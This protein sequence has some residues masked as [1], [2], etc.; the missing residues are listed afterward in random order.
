MS[1]SGSV[2]SSF[3]LKRLRT[4][5]SVAAVTA[6]LT[7]CVSPEN[8]AQQ[9]YDNGLALIAKNDDLN[10]R[11]ELLNSIKYK[12]DNIDV[13]RALAG[14]DERTKATQRLFEDLRRIVE[15]DP[16]DLENRLKLA[17]M[18]VAGGANDAA[19]KLIEIANED[20]KPNAAIHALKALI[21]VRTKDT[22]GAVREAE[23]AL[24]IDPHNVDA[25]TLV[26]AKLASDGDAGA[27]LKLLDTAPIDPKNELRVSL[28]KIQILAQKQDLP[29]AEE[30]LRTL[31]AK[32]P[33]EPSLRP[34]LIQLLIAKKRFD[35]AEKELRAIAAAKTTDSKAG[36]D[37][38]RFLAAS[39]GAD[40]A[41]EELQTRIKAGGDVFDYQMM[42]VDLD[43]ASAKPEEASDLLQNLVGSASTPERKLAAQVKLAENFVRKN[44]FPAAEPI[45]AEILQKDRRNSGAL[46][47]RAAIRIEQGQLDNAI[48]DLR[49]ALNDQAKSTD[50]LLLMAVAYERGG[51]NEL[52]DRQ[53]ADALKSSGLDPRVGSRYVA[54]LQR[55]GDVARAED[56][57]TEVSGRNPRNIDTLSS[58][59]QLKLSRQNWNGALAVAD[60]VE[61]V[62]NSKA[63][64]EQI[65]AAAFAGQNRPDASVDAL[66][67]AHAAAPDAVQPII[68]LVSAY[69]KLGKPE[70]AQSLLQDTLKRFPTN[71]QLLI[72]MGQTQIAG[73]KPVEA[74]QSFKSAVEK[75]PKDLDGYSALSDFY[76]RQKNYDAATNVV[77][78]GLREQP[79]NLNLR[80][81]S[82]GL[83][84]LKGDPGAAIGQY[85]AIL[86]DQPSSLLAINNLVSLILDNRSDEESLNQAYSLAE[87]LKNSNVPEFLDTLGWAQFK[88][89]DYGN[90]VSTLEAAQTRLPKMAA[91][92]YHLGM[93]YA[94]AGQPDKAAE[95][96]K[97]A[98]ALEP[99][100]TTL[101][102]NIR[103]AM[104]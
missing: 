51:K 88:R 81:A 58:L 28:Q 9:Y 10:A 19:L 6:V 80:L 71:A 93:S 8:R 75:Q 69:V 1:E 84:I 48:A 38:V 67:R 79:G 55:R 24:Q 77:Q 70:K 18:L 101:K 47:L 39:K 68:S 5:A 94:A 63:I 26:A 92:H 103:A 62:S 11:L 16:N 82:A 32:N 31:I 76:L 15:L 7:G 29:K 86:K 22:V 100:G 90:A 4:A 85:E 36:L 98:L 35:E 27:A 78:A 54:F 43:F 3:C 96:F 91:A 104:K 56:I 14:V 97:T 59:A 99:D 65:R 49:E 30:L 83:Q 66:E 102:E 57:L 42:L 25:I 41:R 60:T 45:I 61:R 37:L 72:L 64:S 21:L 44:N 50:L 23:R 52:A 46:R 20:G 34:Q 87:K 13:W 73:N 2:K 12:S 53:Y 40:A 33:E 95:Q 74:E 89:G 17:R